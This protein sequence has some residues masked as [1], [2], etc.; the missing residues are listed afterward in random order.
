[1]LSTISSISALSVAFAHDADH[2]LGLR[3]PHHQPAA[4]VKA[5]FGILDRRTDFGI[6][7]RLAAAVAHVLEHLRQ[8][9]EA[10]TDLRHR[11]VLLF[12]HRQHL[13]RRDKPSPVVV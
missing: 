13:Q 9:G 3:R 6:L 7:Q 1:M 10:V 12:H 5:L 8:R 2:R 4:A 11:L